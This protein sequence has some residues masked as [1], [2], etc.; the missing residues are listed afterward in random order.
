M[1]PN[2]RLMPMVTALMVGLVAG[3][4]AR[5]ALVAALAGCLVLFLITA[6]EDGRRR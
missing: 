1:H 2:A 5:S 4:L 6:T 3:T